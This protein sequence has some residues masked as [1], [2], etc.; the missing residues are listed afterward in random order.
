MKGQ[1]RERESFARQAKSLGE[2]FGRG[3]EQ[4]TQRGVKQVTQVPAEAT[5]AARR[6]V[7][8]VTRAPAE[9][10]RAAEHGV[11]GAEFI[12]LWGPRITAGIIGAVAVLGTTGLSYEAVRLRRR[13]RGRR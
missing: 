8:Q 2:R 12:A 5:R 4:L 1:G 9:A 11:K 3:F 7:E 6:G 10:T 13:W